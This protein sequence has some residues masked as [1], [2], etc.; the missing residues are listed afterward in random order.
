M[1]EKVKGVKMDINKNLIQKGL[2]SNINKHQKDNSIRCSRCILPDSYPNISF[3]TEGVCNICRDFEDKWQDTKKSNFLVQEKKLQKI[4]D[5]HRGKWEFDCIVPLSGGKDSTYVLYVVKQ[6]YNLN[7]LAISMDNGFF[8]SIGK[9]NIENAVEILGVEHIMYKPNWKIMKQLYKCCLQIDGIH[10]AVCD[11][12]LC[13]ISEMFAKKNNI[14]LIV[15]GGSPRTQGKPPIEFY[16]PTID[17]LRDI[18]QKANLSDE[19]IWIPKKRNLFLEI[20][21]KIIDKIKGFERI[22]LPMYIEWDEDKIADLLKEKLKWEHPLNKTEHVDCEVD[23]IKNYLWTKQWGFSPKIIKYSDLIRDS[24]MSR[25]DA[26]KRIEVE[27]DLK[28]PEEM[29]YYMKR[30]DLKREDIE[31]A[32]NFR[33]TFPTGNSSKVIK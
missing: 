22:S 28:E 8:T 32:K 20:Y 9:K 33:P 29:D 21:G 2:Q 15:Y 17:H 6:I 13:L 31:N 1:I 18:C 11:T 5:R 10:C 26:L 12:S 30:L 24:Q 25:E 7:V 14:T 4:L 16:N 3:D 27:G 23:S 19:I